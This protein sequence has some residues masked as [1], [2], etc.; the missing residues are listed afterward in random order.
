MKIYLFP[1]LIS[2]C[3]ITACNKDDDRSEKDEQTIQE[4]ITTNNLTTQ[5]TEDGIHYIIEREGTGTRPSISDEVVCHYEGL[6]LDGTKF[7]SSYDRNEPAS[8]PLRG[9][10]PGWQLGIPLFKEGGKGTLIIPSRL[11]YGNQRNGIIPSNSVL[12]FNVE[13]I[14]VK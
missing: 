5:V 7:D 6:L 11:G 2:L 4:Y 10:I 9:V 1:L 3:F 12:L 13:L 14:R 8:F